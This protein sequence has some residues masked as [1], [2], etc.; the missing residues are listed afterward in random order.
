MSAPTTKATSPQASSR[1]KWRWI[2]LA[3]G[4]CVLSWLALG[5]GILLEVG[6]GTMIVLV[7]IAAVATEGTIW[8]AALLLGVSAY[9]V[10]RQLWENVRRRF[11]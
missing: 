2:A 9:Q 7:S 4:V 6:T 1:R 5:A 3:A 8:L 11:R 10:R